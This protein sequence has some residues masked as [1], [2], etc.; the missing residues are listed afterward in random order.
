MLLKTIST[1]CELENQG[2]CVVYSA[3]V[4]YICSVNYSPMDKSIQLVVIQLVKSFGKSNAKIE[5]VYV[6][7]IKG[8]VE[9]AVM[10]EHLQEKMPTAVSN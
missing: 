4:L 2:C 8:N 7:H 1:T 6:G 10:Q 9:K 5:G 3:V